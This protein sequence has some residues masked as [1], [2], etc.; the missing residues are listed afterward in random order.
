MKKRAR[1]YEGMSGRSMASVM[2]LR[3]MKNSIV[4]SN[5]FVPATFWQTSRS[6]QT[7]KQTNKQTNT[8]T[9]RTRQ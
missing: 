5:C 2:Q 8:L 3:A 6:L 4:K 9:V 7:N 1:L